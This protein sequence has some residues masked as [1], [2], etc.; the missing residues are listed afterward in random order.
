MGLLAF[1]TWSANDSDADLQSGFTGGFKRLLR[2]RDRVHASR[3]TGIDGEK[4]PFRLWFRMS[5]NPA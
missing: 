5:A 3:Y 1:A 2:R 4:R